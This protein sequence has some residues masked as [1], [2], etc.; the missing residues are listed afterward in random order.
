MLQ[1]LKA[2]YLNNG[3]L[4]KRIF[5]R[6]EEFNM[7]SVRG[8]RAAT[9]SAARRAAADADW[10]GGTNLISSCSFKVVHDDLTDLQSGVLPAKYRIQYNY[11]SSTT[12]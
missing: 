12:M 5:M 3:D 2:T 7:L 8:W 4:D 11:I 10:G 6:V 1:M 9:W